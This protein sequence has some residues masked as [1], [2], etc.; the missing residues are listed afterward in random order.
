MDPAALL[1]LLVFCRDLAAADLRA[2]TPE[3]LEIVR[4][5]ELLEN[6]DLAED[7]ELFVGPPGEPESTEDAAEAVP[8]APRSAP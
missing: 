5:L 3:D 2:L 1:V 7:L 6:L 8:A 4:H